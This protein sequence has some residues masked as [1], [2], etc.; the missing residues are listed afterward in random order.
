[1]VQ[2]FYSKFT[3]FHYPTYILD[4]L[5]ALGFQIPL[6]QIVKLNSL[7]ICIYLLKQLI[8][9]QNLIVENSNS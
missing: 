8:I 7:G 1:M 2:R 6:S 3:L 4:K 9:F 5:T